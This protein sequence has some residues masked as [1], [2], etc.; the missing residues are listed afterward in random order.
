MGTPFFSIKSLIDKEGSGGGGTA[1][2]SSEISL[3][4][5]SLESISGGA[6]TQE[7]ANSEFVSAIK[8][9]LTIYN[10]TTT[11]KANDYTYYQG[12]VWKSLQSNNKGNTPS[13]GSDYWEQDVINNFSTTIAK[14]NASG[15]VVIN[16][17]LGTA[18]IDVVFYCNGKRVYISY[19]VSAS[20][21][22]VN[23][24]SDFKADYDILVYA[25]KI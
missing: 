3:V 15:E 17:I 22:K 19:D 14:D 1:S 7:G 6:T 25:R 2:K 21:I 24:G 10:E 5:S 16:N 20:E 4:S 8:K 12:E 23:F 18:I 13:V 9:A 11:Y